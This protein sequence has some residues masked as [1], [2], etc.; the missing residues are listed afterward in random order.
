[1][2]GSLRLTY[3]QIREIA[4]INASVE[5]YLKTAYPEAFMFWCDICKSKY[6]CSSQNWGLECEE[7]K[8]QRKETIKSK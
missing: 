8:R 5:A 1:M 6:P 3:K 2:D 4:Q 7:E